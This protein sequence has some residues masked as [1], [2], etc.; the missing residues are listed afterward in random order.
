[1][2]KNVSGQKVG[3]QL[4]S[5]TDGSAFTSAVTVAV[6][7][8]AGTQATGSV[9]SGACAHEGLGLHTYAPAQ[10]ET[11]YDYIAFTFTGTGAVPQTVHIYPLPTTG[12]LAP[13]TAGRTLVV[14]AAGLADA[15]AVKV[16]PTGSGTA[17]TARDI[18][19]S[20]LLS[21][22]TGTGQLDFTSGVVKA[23][24]TQFA[25]QTITAAAG[26]TLPSS[27]ASP[28]NITAGTI[29]T[30]TN[31]TNLPTIPANWLTAA[32]TAADFTTE[33]QAGL[34]T[35]TNITAGTI[36]TVTNLT[37]APTNGDLTATMKASVTT[38]ATAA[39]PTAAAV[40]G[41][42]GSVTGNVGGNV[43]GSVGSISGITFPTNFAALGINASGHVSRV[44][45]TDSVTSGG[46]LDA[47]G[48]R[49]AL[50][51]ATANL[52][53]QLTDLPTLAEFN[54]R[55]LVAANYFDP[56][57]DSVIVGTNNDKT[58]YAL[59]AGG[60]TAVQAG[61]ALQASVD[62]LEGRLTEVRAGYL[63]HLLTIFTALPDGGDQIAGE[64]S[65]TVQ[66]AETRDLEPP[67]WVWRLSRRSDG[68]IESP[69]TLRMAPG[70]SITAGFDC[71]TAFVL[72]S[73]AVVASFTDPTGLT[74][75][76]SVT[77]RGTNGQ[78]CTMTIDCAA[79]ATVGTEQT[80]S[81]QMTNS[82]GDGPVILTARVLVD[83]D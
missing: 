34:A 39:T 66:P 20:V 5:A 81:I 18:G 77:K 75:P 78:Y 69:L 53:A 65:L 15:N 10:A 37:N 17:Q 56:A 54:A 30:T 25:G 1:M 13:A 48:T 72:P 8:D 74:T 23:N 58:G 49:A 26:V 31:L 68:D 64:D 47:A 6:T 63:D 38:A 76:F 3:C 50:G 82:L 9:G 83:D 59:S 33:I 44:T 61:L 11:N 52:D 4:V 2:K 80:V 36:T 79:G 29:T 67:Q 21:S 40:T 46:G 62:D 42:V 71:K 27:V 45:V 32:G 16:G 22:G 43:T 70:E 60:V 35:P 51:L 24:A 19:A 14:D 28:T 55:T 7:G 41:A 12:I 57:A 73:G